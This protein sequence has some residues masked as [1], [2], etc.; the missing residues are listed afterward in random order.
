MLT[1][2]QTNRHIYTGDCS[3]TEVSSDMIYDTPRQ[4]GNPSLSCSA[5]AGTDSCPSLPGL[6]DIQNYMG[7]SLFCPLFSFKS[8]KEEFKTQQIYYDSCRTHFTPQQVTFMQNTIT[9]LKPTLVKQLVPGC[10]S[11]IDSTDDSADL[12]PCIS[13]VFTDTAHSSTAKAWCYTDKLDSA[14]WGW[15]CCP[16]ASGAVNTACRSGVFNMN[17][18]GAS[19]G[20]AIPASYPTSPPIPLWTP[21]LIGDTP[22]SSPVKVPAPGPPSAPPVASSGCQYNGCQLPF[23]IVKGKGKTAKT[24]KYSAPITVGKYRPYK[25]ASLSA[26]TLWCPMLGVQ[27]VGGVLSLSCLLSRTNLFDHLKYSTRA[28]LLVSRRCGRKQRVN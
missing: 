11:S 14:V 1:L 5:G 18:N 16:L 28:P 4:S 12:R 2:Q 22:T 19:G 20:S 25:S 7:V 9:A 23:S 24:V 10:V 3:G 17:N 27:Q 21:P 15:A 26:Q 8:D 6:D 13:E